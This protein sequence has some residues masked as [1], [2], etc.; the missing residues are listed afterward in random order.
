MS[1]TA[2]PPRPPEPLNP[3]L[4]EFTVR[5]NHPTLTPIDFERR[6]ALAVSAALGTVVTADYQRPC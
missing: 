1:Y 2:Q 6:I 3:P 4:H 5:F